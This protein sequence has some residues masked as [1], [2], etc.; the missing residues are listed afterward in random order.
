MSIQPGERIPEAVLQTLRDGVQRSPRRL[1][2]GRKRV[3]FSVP[4]AHADV[5]GAPPAGYVELDA[6]AKGI[7]CLR[8]S[9]ARNVAVAWAKNQSVP[10]A[11]TMLAGSNDFA[12]RLGLEFDASAFNTRRTRSGPLRRD[13]V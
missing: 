13:G 1:F 6:T 10:A 5:F 11:I 12:R 3:L 4:S 7:R 9:L 8:G 2:D